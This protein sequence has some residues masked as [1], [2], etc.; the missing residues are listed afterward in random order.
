MT[1]YPVGTEDLLV[2]DQG[3]RANTDV[4]SD[5]P[6]FSSEE[7]RSP[8]PEESIQGPSIGFSKRGKPDADSAGPDAAKK[9]Q[10]LQQTAEPRKTNKPPPKDKP[11]PA[12]YSGTSK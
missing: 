5:D 1:S 4:D 9:Y 7:E 2:Q 8:E 12:N 11:K 10:T 6:D 3:F